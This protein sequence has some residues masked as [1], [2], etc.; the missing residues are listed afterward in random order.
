[1]VSNLNDTRA[2][3]SKTPIELLFNKFL[4]ISINEY[5]YHTKAY[6]EYDEEEVF[7]FIL[8]GFV[9]FTHLFEDD[10]TELDSNIIIYNISYNQVKN[11]I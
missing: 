4:G 1:M 5:I 2:F 9:I 11:N 8:R 3:I 10:E 6:L 7:V